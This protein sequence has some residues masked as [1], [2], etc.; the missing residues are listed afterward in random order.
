MGCDFQQKVL[1]GTLIY[2]NLIPPSPSSLAVSTSRC[3]LAKGSLLTPCLMMECSL[4]SLFMQ[5][6]NYLPCLWPTSGE[7]ESVEEL[8]QQLTSTYLELQS[9]RETA[10]LQS[11]INEAKICRLQGLLDAARK[12]RDEARTKCS[13]LQECLLQLSRSL[14]VP[15]V[16]HVEASMEPDATTVQVDALP[17]R[18]KLLQAVMQAGPLLQNLLLAGPLP[19]WRYPPPQLST[20][21]IPKVPLVSSSLLL[22]YHEG[23]VL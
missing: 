14:Q 12:E 19:Q 9:T 13:K 16:T 3:Q 17:V 7:V 6:G 18:G 15:K 23:S 5:E 10:T 21:G 22:K 4:A 2:L 8:Q 20:L 1:V 11:R